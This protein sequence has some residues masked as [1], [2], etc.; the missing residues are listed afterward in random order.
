VHRELR[1][2]GRRHELQAQAH[3][4]PNQHLKLTVGKRNLSAHHVGM[5]SSV[6]AKTVPLSCCSESRLAC[7][8][9]GWQA[10]GLALSPLPPLSPSLAQGRCWFVRMADVM[11]STDG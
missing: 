2:G 11:A 6:V 3:K 5:Q 4:Q 7:R 10:G 1:G 8:L 9:A